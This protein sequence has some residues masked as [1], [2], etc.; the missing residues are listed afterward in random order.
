MS[1]RIAAPPRAQVARLKQQLHATAMHEA[2]H[3]VAG[4]LLDIPLREVWIGYQ[5]HGW[6]SWSVVGRTE[7]VI[8]GDEPPPGELS[9]DDLNDAILFVWAGLEAEAMWLEEQTG[10]RLPAAR[11]TVA[12]VSVHQQGDLAALR[13]YH[14]DRRARWPERRA[15]DVARQL[16]LT[17]RDR[18]E[19]VARAL[20][21]RGCISGREVHALVK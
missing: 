17:R 20:V 2:G 18:V 19:D 6:S 4:V 21:E 12:S 10:V 15:Q 7:T 1:G 14:K 11:R 13:G 5:K 9:T 8:D 16:V 3:A